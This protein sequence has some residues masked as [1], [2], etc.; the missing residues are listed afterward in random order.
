MQSVQEEL[1]R[2]EHLMLESEKYEHVK[3]E[4]LE[5]VVEGMGV[6]EKKYKF[7]QKNSGVVGRML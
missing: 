3:T 1:M 2:Q 6:K 7:L 4:M 5:V